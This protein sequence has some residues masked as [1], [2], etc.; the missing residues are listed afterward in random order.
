RLPTRFSSRMHGLSSSSE[1]RPMSDRRVEICSTFLSSIRISRKSRRSSRRLILPTMA[2][3]FSRLTSPPIKS[4]T[5]LIG[6][7]QGTSSASL[8]CWLGHSPRSIKSDT[9]EKAFAVAFLRREAVILPHARTAVHFFLKSLALR[10]GDEVLMTPLT[11]A[12]M[13]NSI[14]TAG[15]KPVFVEMESGTCNFDLTALER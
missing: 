15:L 7:F 13:V 2:A 10:P 4:K 6:P 9:F 11:I 1:Y 12:D 5:L 8:F 3:I 14:H